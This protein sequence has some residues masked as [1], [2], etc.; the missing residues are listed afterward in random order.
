MPLPND[1]RSSLSLTTSSRSFTSFSVR[2]RVSAP[3]TQKA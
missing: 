3:L 1:E 2:I